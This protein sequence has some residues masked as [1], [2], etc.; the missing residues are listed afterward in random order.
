M[1]N[2][3]TS[4]SQ[5]FSFII[6]YSITCSKGNNYE[7]IRNINL[8]LATQALRVFFAMICIKL[9]DYYMI[10]FITDLSVVYR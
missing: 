5:G 9:Y 4:E 3:K 6:S 7:G 10:S 8:G 1:V 2:P